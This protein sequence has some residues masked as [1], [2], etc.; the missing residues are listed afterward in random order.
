MEALQGR[1]VLDM[2]TVASSVYLVCSRS[3]YDRYSHNLHA[4]YVSRDCITYRPLAPCC[5]MH[6]IVNSSSARET[7]PNINKY[8]KCSKKE[9]TQ[10]SM[11]QLMMPSYAP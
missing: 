7:L 1:Y 4:M 8:F 11:R 6:V 10:S 2:M 3:V 5:A 9:F